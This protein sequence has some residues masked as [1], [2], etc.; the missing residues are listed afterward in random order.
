M[1]ENYL[2]RFPADFDQAMEAR[3]QLAEL[4]LA[5]GDKKRYHHWL[6]EIIAAHQ[7]AGTQATERS[8]YL[9]AHA[10]LA[11]ADAS[12]ARFN[13]VKL[14]E[15]IKK[16]LKLKRKYLQSSL[17]DYEKC[18]TFGVADVTTAATYRIAELYSEFAKALWDSQRPAGLDELALEQYELMLE[19]QAIPFED[20]AI[21]LHEV[22]VGLTQKE[23]IYTPWSARS[24]DR[25]AELY[26]AR[27][28]R[29]ERLE[30][31]FTSL[32]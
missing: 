32:Q 20:K 18:A 17:A 9:A 12:L 6:K 4:A 14:V 19:E 30:E 3:Q 23:G 10:T 21:E 7:N 11:L 5:R 22:N 15:P 24:Y 8:R 25:L 2:R 27:Y 16:N 28:N 31:V 26:P 1:L 29:K 13:A